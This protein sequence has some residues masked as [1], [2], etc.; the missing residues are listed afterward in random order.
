LKI[1]EPLNKAGNMLAITSKAREMLDSFVEKSGEE[2]LTLRI[3]IIGR[4]PKGFQYDLQF[5]GSDGGQEDDVIADVEGVS[6][7]VAIRS[8]QYL[9]GTT[10]DFKETLMGGGFAF[11]N[12]NPMWID[13][14]SIRVA[15]IIN[16]KVNPAVASH[17]GVVELIGVDDDKAII[18]FGGGCQGCGMADVTLKQG[19][20]V[21]IKENVPE[22][23][24]VVDTT[25]HAAGSNPFY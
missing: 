11:D 23:L 25:D 14:L 5:V 15:E 17:G 4:G 6:V 8:A 2:D 10:L 24:E 9:D 18:A 13:E 12:P 19:V 21:M 7:R 20:E 1:E 16:E 3:E 22:I